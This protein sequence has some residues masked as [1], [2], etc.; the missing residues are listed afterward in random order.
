MFT[1]RILVLLKMATNRKN[2]Q[3]MLRIL[4]SA[5]SPPPFCN[6]GRLVNTKWVGKRMITMHANMFNPTGL[7]YCKFHLVKIS[8]ASPPHL[9]LN[10][11]IFLAAEQ[12]A[13]GCNGLRF[14]SLFS[15][16]TVITNH[17]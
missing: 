5:T 8:E 13:G 16:P 6:Q 14:E 11:D 2:R 1:D 9:N 4:G 12:I 15:R 10:F 17:P 3:W 7:S